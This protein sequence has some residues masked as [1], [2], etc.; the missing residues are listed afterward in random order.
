MQAL[1]KT[2]V[3]FILA[4]SIPVAAQS[5]RAP[6]AVPSAVA[7]T[8]SPASDELTVKQ[9]FDEA[10]GYTKAKFAEYAEKKTPYNDALLARTKLEQRQLAAR[11]ATI[12]GSRKNLA[13][14]DLYYLGMLHWIAENFDGTAD[15]LRRF[16][17]SE[18]AAA[19][20]AQTA[21]SIIVVALAK[22]KKSDEAEKTL[23]EYLAKEPKKL[24]ERARVEGEL[25]KAYQAQKDFV[26][27]APHAEEDYAAAKGL[28][29]DST[30][31]ARG[32]DE[33]LDAGM[34]VYEAY[35]DLGN[36][37]KAEA[38][39][40][41]MKATAASTGSTSF[42]YYAVDQKIKFLIETGRKPAAMEFYAATLANAE[43]DFTAKDLQGDIKQRLK[44][45]ERHYKLLDEPAP[46]LPVEVEWFPGKQRT[47]ASMKGKVVLLDF[48]ATWCAP[49]FDAF[50]SLIEWQQ[51]LR[52]DGLEII[53][54]TRYYREVNGMPADEVSELKYLKEFRQRERLPYDMVVGQDQNMQLT[55][56]GTGL[57]TAVLI[58]R[59]GIVRYVE[60]GTSPTRIEQMRQMVIK[61]LAEK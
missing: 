13:G 35:R 58:D 7:S 16:T 59:K 56:G 43:K 24:T 53:G 39:L 22:Q 18:N 15:A 57:P 44:R 29:K 19:D 61:L 10:N 20:R 49:C 47:L 21:R 33:I 51:D 36:R 8:R 30:S 12:A 6:Q 1:R 3:F 5:G 38:A 14:D 23:A 34:L 4:A 32:L 17:A 37:E 45:R 50:P 42:Y 40:D 60:S 26:K 11:Y 2:A 41:D 25:A 52:S 48:W 46:E 55:Y 9:M 54:I 28:L 31:R 27:M